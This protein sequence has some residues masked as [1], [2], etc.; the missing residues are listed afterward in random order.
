[1]GKKGSG[2][3]MFLLVVAIMAAWTSPLFAKTWETGP[4]GR[5]DGVSSTDDE[6]SQE[7]LEI[8][9]EHVRTLTKE[10]DEA[11]RQI[12]QLKSQHTLPAVSPTRARFGAV[13]T[14]PPP[15]A[16]PLV[17]DLRTQMMRMQKELQETKNDKDIILRDK[18]KAL[19]ELEGLRR[20]EPTRDRGTASEALQAKLRSIELEQQELRD[21]RDFLSAQVDALEKENEKLRAE[22]EM[23]RQRGGEF[24]RERVET[25]SQM[26]SQV[27]SLEKEKEELEASIAGSQSQAR[28][29]IQRLSAVNET[30]RLEGAKSQELRD[31]VQKMSADKEEFQRE[32]AR[33]S[34]LIDKLKSKNAALSSNLEAMKSQEEELASYR[35]MEADYRSQRDRLASLSQ[36]AAA[37]EKE[38]ADL[39][40]RQESYQRKIDGLESALQANLADIANLK[41]NFESYLESLATGFE[42][43]LQQ[44]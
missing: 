26:R 20:G 40:G 9:K 29:E 3:F 8:W 27:A 35:K 13:E 12:D 24:D 10:R 11:Y 5:T 22:V 25:A 4:I 17:Q 16:S 1:M 15:A 38:N 32:L 2:F 21:A 44:K 42:D 19:R 14:A 7:L 37:L 36:R 31:Q 28:R 41:T 18:E 23:L 30:L 6:R 33:T 43:R 39:E 34:T